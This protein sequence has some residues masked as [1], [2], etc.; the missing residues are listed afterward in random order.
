MADLNGNHLAHDF[1][2]QYCACLHV[3]LVWFKRAAVILNI[4]VNQNNLEDCVSLL[5]NFL[6]FCNVGWTV[7]VGHENTLLKM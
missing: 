1:I 4:C 5:I 3:F 6:V 2:Y 7:S